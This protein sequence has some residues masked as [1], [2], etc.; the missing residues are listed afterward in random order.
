MPAASPYQPIEDYGVTG[1]LRTVALTGRDGSIDWFCYPDIDSPSVF[2]ALLDVDKGGRFQVSAPGGPRRGD[3]R[4]LGDTNV[5]ETS[6]PTEGGRLTITDFL[7]LT[8]DLDGCG[9]STAYP[10]LFRVVTAEGDVEAAVTWAPRFDYAR[11]TTRIERD[12]GR[13]VATDGTRW[14]GLDGLPPGEHSVVRDEQGNDTLQVHLHLADGTRMA[15]VQCWDR[16]APAGYPRAFDLLR[17]TIDAWEAWAHKDKT[18][19]TREWAAP[20]D[21]LVTR[22]ELVLKL[23]THG[24]TGAIAAAGTTS[25][26]ETIGGIRNWDYRYAWI[27]DAGMTGQAFVATGHHAE[28]QAFVNWIER[29]SA[30]HKQSGGELYVMYSVRGETVLPEE[31][32]SHFEGYRGS[33]PVKIGNE[34]ASQAQHDVLGE[35]LDAADELLSDGCELADDI[36]SFLP[37]VAD[38]AAEAWREPDHGLWE[39]PLEAAHYV[40]SKLMTWVALD[41]AVRL[42]EEQGLA[43]DVERWRRAANE[44]RELILEQGYSQEKRAFVQRF[45]SEAMD[46]SGL[47]IPIEGLISFDDQRAQGTIDQVQKELLDEGLVRRYVVDD[48]L[49]GKE[50]GWILCT[51]WLINNLV[52]SGREREGIELYERLAGR[53]NHLGLFAEQIDPSTGQFLGNFPQAL[54]HIGFIESTLFVAHAQGRDVPTAIPPTALPRHH[55]PRP[56]A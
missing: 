23:L 29:T 4:Y 19:R 14:L 8:G 54:S 5:L 39:M 47:M 49:P 35:I 18:T 11:T 6:F 56:G 10:Y 34:A 51:T 12:G 46:A 30:A 16:E 20:Y 52:L 1:N 7:P 40:Y 32:L 50:G 13:F 9:G 3:Q 22:S 15:L 25:L 36:W 28:M 53:A 42:A 55:R 48:G 37:A 17:E 26:P 24:E 27:R 43:G 31:E 38:L 45:G 33:A 41:R 44:V 21:Q 2:A